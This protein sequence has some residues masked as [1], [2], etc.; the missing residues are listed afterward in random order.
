M[1]AAAKMQGGALLWDEQCHFEG[2]LYMNELE[3]SCLL[4][5]SQHF[6]RQSG[7]CRD[8]RCARCVKWVTVLPSGLVSRCRP[9]H[10]TPSTHRSQHAKLPHGSSGQVC[11]FE[12]PS[13]WQLFL[14][15]TYC[16]L[17]QL[18]MIMYSDFPVTHWVLLHHNTVHSAPSKEHWA[19][20]ISWRYLME[21]QVYRTEWAWFG[22]GEWYVC[23]LHFA[24]GTPV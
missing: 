10:C 8:D 3:Y 16:I 19:R 6:C 2:G 17:L 13:F 5:T 14:E 1:I 23:F 11:N 22:R 4:K 9:C 24:H 12:R 18:L 20:R 7:S 15:Y 21:W